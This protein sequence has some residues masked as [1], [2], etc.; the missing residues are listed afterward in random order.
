[1][2]RLADPCDLLALVWGP[3]VDRDEVVAL[4]ARQPALPPGT[5][6]A[7][8]AAADRFDALPAARQQRLRERLHRRATGAVD[9]AGMSI[10]TLLTS[11]SAPPGGA[12]ASLKRL[13][14]AECPASC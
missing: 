6:A 3:R 2:A 4:L 9:N 1:M 12:A 14:E 10:P 11:C 7:W 13:G 5:L 8:M